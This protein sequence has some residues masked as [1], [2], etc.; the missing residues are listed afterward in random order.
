MCGPG[1]SSRRLDYTAGAPPRS[2]YDSIIPRNTAGAYRS[3][4]K[5]MGVGG[6]SFRAHAS[7]IPVLRAAVELAEGPWF[8][9]AVGAMLAAVSAAAAYVDGAYST[10]GWFIL[11]AGREIAEAGIPRE[12]PWADVEG[13]GVVVQQWLHDLWAWTWYEAAGF[14]GLDAMVALEALALT[15]AAWAFLPA[16]RRSG[17][18]GAGAAAIGCGATVLAMAPYVNVRP[19][20]WT[21]CAVLCACGICSAARRDRRLYALLPALTALHVNLHA[22]MWPLPAVAAACFLLP[23]AWGR[24]HRASRRAAADWARSRAPLAAALLGMAAASLANPYGIEGSLY[25]LAGAGEAAYGGYIREMRPFSAV[26][27]VDP[28]FALYPAAY[29]AALAAAC[30]KA[31]RPPTPAAAAFAAVSLAAGLLSARNIWIFQVA[32]TMAALSAAGEP[33][34]RSRLAEAACPLLIAGAV[35]CGMAGG[36]AGS[37]CPDPEE[38][39]GPRGSGINAGGIP[40]WESGEALAPLAAAMAAE[41]GGRVFCS[42][43]VGMAV[44]EFYGCKVPFDLRPEVWAPEIT[45]IEGYYPWRDY[46]DACAGAADTARYLAEYGFRWAVVPDADASRWKEEFGMVE[47]ASSDGWSLLEI[48]GRTPL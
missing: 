36:L 6:E 30:I 19:T 44:L 47:T 8:A 11:A 28:F 43:D 24:P 23:D 3:K 10:D 31:R 25:G 20:A 17:R 27:A 35:A 41:G 7:R 21:A 22:A 40:S 32:C 46:A 13:M 38:A 1:T 12:N 9:I 14:G 5:G 15:L 26:V 29:V 2:W 37:S 42:T 4:G 45:G 33:P 34:R 48:A 39:E 18:P 16:M